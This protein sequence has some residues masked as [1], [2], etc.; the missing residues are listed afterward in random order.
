MQLQL[1]VFWKGSTLG[2]R[3]P[4]EGEADMA[5]HTVDTLFWLH[6]PVETDQ[7]A[8]GAQAVK[9]GFTSRIE[10]IATPAARDLL[11]IKDAT[12]WELKPTWLHMRILH[13][14]FTNAVPYL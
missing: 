6:G 5:V 9:P 10:R 3:R 8:L 7:D 13:E 14:A 1:T 4:V 12:L 11:S 2:P